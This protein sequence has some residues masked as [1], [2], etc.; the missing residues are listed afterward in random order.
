MKETN[1]SSSETLRYVAEPENVDL[2]FKY[3]WK[4]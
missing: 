2:R 4:N 1:T 3:T